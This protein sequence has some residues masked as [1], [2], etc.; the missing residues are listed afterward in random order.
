GPAVNVDTIFAGLGGVADVVT[1]EAERAAL[2][3]QHLRERGF[4]R[5]AYFAPP[6]HRYSER[7]GQEFGA[8]VNAAGY[9]LHEYR[10]PH[11]GGRRLSWDE[12]QRRVSNW[13]DALP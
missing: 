11:R 9:A 2:A 10:P 3:F 7:L 12:Q 1:D 6:S 5:F 13:L 8:L 4:E